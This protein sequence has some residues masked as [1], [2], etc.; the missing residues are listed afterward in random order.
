M[1]G[2]EEQKMTRMGKQKGLLC[3]LIS[4]MV[5]ELAVQLEKLRVEEHQKRE[6]KKFSPND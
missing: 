2:L 1:E 6:K 5:T 3:S 4:E